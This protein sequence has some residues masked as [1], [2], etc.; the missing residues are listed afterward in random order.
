MSLGEGKAGPY[1]RGWVG[2]RA[3]VS[4]RDNKVTI[5]VGMPV[6][7]STLLFLRTRCGCGLRQ[8]SISRFPGLEAGL[9]VKAKQQ[10]DRPV[11][12][13]AAERERVSLSG[14]IFLFCW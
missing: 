9:C 14:C 10:R 1:V 5:Q 2:W 11:R 13:V 6:V 7:R 8:L 12:A 4:E 3:T